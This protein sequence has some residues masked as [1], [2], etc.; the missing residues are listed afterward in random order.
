MITRSQQLHSITRFI[1]TVATKLRQIMWYIQIA[2]YTNLYISQ[3][4]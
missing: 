4:G 3:L 1:L 2:V